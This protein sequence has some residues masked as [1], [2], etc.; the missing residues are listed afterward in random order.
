[1]KV[2]IYGAGRRIEDFFC[3]CLYLD[4]LQILCIADRDSKKWG[5]NYYG[6]EVCKPDVI[7]QH[8][9]QKIIVL[10][11][12]FR[13]IYS[14]LCKEFD[15]NENELMR[16]EDLIVPKICNLG[17]LGLACRYDDAYDIRDIIPS[18]VIPHNRLEQFFFFEKHRI[19]WK[20]W[21]YF[22]IYHKYFNNYVNK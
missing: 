6:Y 8:N 21:H 12:V 9:W 5:K 17:S 18:K 14:Q 16:P 3:N 22:E 7:R 1:M 11:D 19:I 4:Y 2:I 10:P 15:L 13:E 20:W